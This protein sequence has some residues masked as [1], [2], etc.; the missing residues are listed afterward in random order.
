VQEA[1]NASGHAVKRPWDM[2][3]QIETSLVFY[4][5]VRGRT[6]GKVIAFCNL[7]RKNLE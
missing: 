5:G 3:D 1:K 7:D 6:P 2:V 4:W